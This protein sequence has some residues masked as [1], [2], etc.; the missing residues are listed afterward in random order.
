MLIRWF[1]SSARRCIL[2]EQ[3]QLIAREWLKKQKNFIIPEESID[4]TFS[5]SSGKGGQNVNKT[6]SKATA[7]MQVKQNWLPKYVHNALREDAHYVKS[8]DSV[9]VSDSSTR[10]AAQN[11]RIA[12]NRLESI[13]AV[14]SKKGIINETAPGKAQRVDTFKRKEKANMEKMKKYQKEKKALRRNRNE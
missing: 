8:S 1:Y 5:K 2:D 13:I 9:V 6:S 14:A 11:S 4:F 10:S 7:R 12:S 3:T